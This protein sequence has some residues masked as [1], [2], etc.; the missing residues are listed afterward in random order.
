MYGIAI[1]DLKPKKGEHKN[2]EAKFWGYEDENDLWFNVSSAAAWYSDLDI[3]VDMDMSGR[4]MLQ[5]N[6]KRGLLVFGPLADICVE[7]RHQMLIINAIG[8][9]RE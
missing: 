8:R 6:K 7:H 3:E 2:E 4:N 1:S 5:V 9:E